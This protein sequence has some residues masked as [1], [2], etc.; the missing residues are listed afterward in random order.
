[1]EQLFQLVSLATAVTFTLA[2]VQKVWFLVRAP[3]QPFAPAQWGCKAK[4]PWQVSTQM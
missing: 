3:Q 4:S 1:M 2:A